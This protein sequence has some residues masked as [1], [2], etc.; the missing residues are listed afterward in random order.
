MLPGTQFVQSGG[1]G[2]Y[3]KDLVLRFY[4]LVSALEEDEGPVGQLAERSTALQTVAR[5]RGSTVV[6]SSS[7]FFWYHVDNLYESLDLGVAVTIQQLQLFLA[8]LLD[9]F[10]P[11][12]E[13]RDQVCL[14]AFTGELILP[15]LGLRIPVASE[16]LRVSRLDSQHLQV[17]GIDPILKIQLDSPG[18]HRLPVARLSDSARLLF[19]VD[20]LL[21]DAL[22]S[23]KIA[24]LTKAETQ[25]YVGMLQRSLEVV[26]EIDP[27]LADHLQSVV[28]WYFPIE[29]PDKGNIHNS[30]TI[31]SLSG[32]VFL[33]ESYT[34]LPLLE[35]L[36]HEFYH[37][38]LWMAM[39]VEK[40]LRDA[41]EENL[42]SPWRKDARPLIGLY[43]GAY[44]FT[45]LLDF[46]AT[47]E[48]VPSLGNSH[49]HFRARRIAIYYQVRTALEQFPFD[50]MEERGRE[51]VEAL[52]Q[53][54]RSHG[55][56][57]GADQHAVPDIQQKHWLDWKALYPDFS[58]TAKPPVTT[59]YPNTVLKGDGA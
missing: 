23:K 44:V 47:A 30:F 58:L 32:A 12:L 49:Q 37:N 13:E 34:L 7:S 27:V 20:S 53:I 42:Y 35:A 48:Q 14:G 50:K 6:E 52:S 2:Q 25:L 19:G 51:Y 36:V 4:L 57:L 38:E 21:S 17:E 46:F 1:R 11:L 9:S 59:E 29:T 18:P 16:D 31:A 41:P 5:H 55:E 45:G 8:Q 3:H 28:R 54:V 40:H 22:A 15:C 33:S 24:H 39:R 56:S 26:T 10:Y 43:H